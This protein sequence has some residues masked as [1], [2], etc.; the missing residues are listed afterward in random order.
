[1]AV[2]TK[3]PMSSKVK[4]ELFCAYDHIKDDGYFRCNEYGD[5]V[6]EFCER[7]NTHLIPETLECYYQ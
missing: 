5:K 7:G 3:K 6:L 2:R 4:D 1:M